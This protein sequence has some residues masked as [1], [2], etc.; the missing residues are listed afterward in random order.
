MWVLG[1][2]LGGVGV[3]ETGGLGRR[4]EGGRWAGRRREGGRWAVKKKGRQDV[5]V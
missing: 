1:G 5:Y 3:W 2:S 4:R